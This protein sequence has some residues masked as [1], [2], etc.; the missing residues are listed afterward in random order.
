MSLNLS[1][2]NLPQP[3]GYKPEK[4]PLHAL[5]AMQQRRVAA[6][7][8]QKAA[9]REYT[10]TRAKALMAGMALSMVGVLTVFGQND[11]VPFEHREAVEQPAD[12]AADESD[13][14]CEL[15]VN[16]GG[17]AWNVAGDI[18]EKYNLNQAAVYTDLDKNNPQIG[19][20]LDNQVFT[21]VPLVF[22]DDSI[23]QAIANSQS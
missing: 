5:T 4:D 16:E 1:T 17:Y 2:S 22:S 10:A 19:E 20:H 8:E 23:C 14:T 6:Q 18:A 11:S 15:T 7:Q 9:G 3:N 12:P 13:I 21:S